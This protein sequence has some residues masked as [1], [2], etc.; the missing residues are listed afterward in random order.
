MP[1]RLGSVRR[2]FRSA[3]LSGSLSQDEPKL[4]RRNIRRFHKLFFRYFSNSK[5]IKP[6]ERSDIFRLIHK[7]CS[8]SAASLRISWTSDSESGPIKS[9]EAIIQMSPIIESNDSPFQNISIFRSLDSLDS[10]EH[11]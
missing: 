5:R 2:P 9:V 6:R 4:G 7:V 8:Q 1:F 11:Y 3:S 10:E